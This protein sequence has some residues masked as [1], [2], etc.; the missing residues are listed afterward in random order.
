MVSKR[1]LRLCSLIFVSLLAATGI[2][3]CRGQSEADKKGVL[4]GHVS[5]VLMG[6][7]TPDGERAVTFSTDETARLWDLKSGNEIRQYTGH[8]GPLYCG[9]LSGDGRTLV[10]GAQDNTLRLWDVPQLRPVMFLAGHEGKVG[11][12]AVSPDGRMIVSGAADKAVRLWDIGNVAD[13]IAAKK[14][15]LEA[16]KEYSLRNGHGSQV[17]TA[18]WRNDSANF[19]TA[20]ADGRIFVWSPYLDAPQ[21]EIGLHPGGVT[22]LAFPNNNQQLISTGADGVIRFWQLPIP[23]T[24]SFEGNTAA[25]SAIAMVTNQAAGVVGAADGTLRLFDFNTGTVTRELPKSDKPVT[26]ADVQPNN[27]LIA[28]ADDTGRVRLLNF[29]DGADRGSILG[30]DGAVNR[31]L[32]HPDNT[33]LATAG[34][35]GTV[36]LWTIP[37]TPVPT[38]GHSQPL[39]A[40]AAANNGQWF[41]TGAD[42]KT[43]RVWAA[44]GQAQRQLGNHLQPVTVVAVRGDDAQIASG[45]EEGKI[46]LWNAG[47]GAAEGSLSA[48]TGPVRATAFEASNQSLLTGGDDGL[49]KR[50]QLPLVEPRLSNGHSQP[51]QAVAVAPDGS[52]MVTGSPDATVRVWNLS[53]GQQVRTLDGQTGPVH[54][55]AISPNGQQ[56]AAVGEAGQILVWKLADGALE[57]KRHGLAGALHDVAF[58]PDGNGLVTVDADQA[59]RLWHL[60]EAAKEIANDGAPYQVAAVSVD[61]KLY[62]VAGQSGGKHAV[63]VRER[64]SGKVVATLTGH[65]AAVTALAFDKS[66]NRLITGSADKT[67]RVWKLDGGL[68]ELF[69]HEG[70]PGTVLAVALSDDA[71]T[72]FSSGSENVVRQWNVADGSEIRSIAGHSAA[73]RGLAVRGDT[74]FSAADDGTV[75][76]WNVQNGAAIRTLN[77]G[78][79]LRCLSVTADGT[80]VVSGGTD[81]TAKLWN[82]ADGALISTFAGA[83]AEITAAVFSHD[84]S[85]VAVA[86]TDG[87]RVWQSDGRSVEHI[88]APAAALQGVVWS[89]D[90][91]SLLVCRT[92]GKV[93]QHGLSV[94]Q[95]VPLPDAGTTCVAVAPDGK[96]LFA[97][98]TGKVVRV[99]SLAEGRVANVASTKSFTGPADVVTDITVSGDGKLLAASSADKSAYVWDL[100]GTNPAAMQKFDHATAVRG[101]SLT[102]DGNRLAAAGDD[103][104]TVLWDLKTRQSAERIPGPAQAIRAVAVTGD[105]KLVVTA[106]QDNSV[107]TLTPAVTML[108]TASEAGPAPEAVTHLVPLPGDAGF[109]ALNKS[110]KGVLRWNPDGTQ[111]PSL[112]PPE[113][114]LNSLR[115]SADGLR[116]LATSATGQG[117]AWSVADGKLQT[118]LKFGGKISDAA[119]HRDGAEVAV[120]DGQSRVRVFSLEPFRLLEEIATPAAV[121]NVEWTGADGRQLATIGPQNSGSVATRSLQRLWDGLTGGAAT[122][123]FPTNGAQVFAAGKDGTIHQWRTA[124]GVLER[125]LKGHTMAVTDLTVTPNGQQLL[126][127]GKDKTLRQWNLADGSAMQSIAHAGVVVGVSVRSDSQ[128]AAT[129]SEDGQVR[130]WD[131]PSGVLLQTFASHSKEGSAVRWLPDGVTLVSGAVDKTLAGVKTSIIRAIPAHEKP[132]ADLA[133]YAGGAQVVTCSPDAQVVL[134]DLNGGQQVRKF[135]GLAAEPRCVAA[136]LDNQRIAA[137]TADGKLLVWN[138]GN[139]QLLQTIEVGQAVTALAYSADN[140]KLAVLDE[141]NMLRIYGPPV[142]PQQA[143]GGI[144]LFLHQEISSPQPLTRIAFSPDNRSVW[145]AQGDGAVSEWAY[146]SPGQIRQF[147]HGGS[148]YGVALSRD[149]KTV[150][151]CSADQTVRVWDAV[152]GQQRFQLNGHVGAVH[153]V[154]LSPDESLIV[155]SGADKTVRL[156]DLTG[157]RQL[158]QLATLD[159][160]MYSVAV[161]PDGKLV[162]AAG[163]DHKVHVYEL[164]TGAERLT[165]EGHTDYIH[166]V[167][168]NPQGTR[169]LSYGNA[170]QLRIWNAAD[171]KLLFEH[172]VGKI[173]NFADYAADGKRALLSNGDATAQIFEIPESAR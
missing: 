154:A 166:C 5:P 12:V 151:S 153:A 36:R 155:S 32:F 11:G 115:A 46:W 71:V 118:T 141:K 69:K 47:N 138:A 68:A 152:T 172:R 136:R 127:T 84:S 107:R 34:A 124:D 35:D 108:L 90:A 91:D 117:Y 24:R 14:P 54:S 6:V 72:A 160:T 167:T 31:V 97:S 65:E 132:I 162:A 22:G 142:P 95:V 2:Q 119:F 110:G 78:G 26:S 67:V 106:G 80:K 38:N 64:D 140:Q 20:D 45:D 173:G 8:T 104:S 10:T 83:T 21:G 55:V 94:G 86:A 61:G 53:N 98:G 70:Y 131:L 59:L 114:D 101:V 85:R 51:V 56:A 143:Q 37:T 27:A 147:N 42:D 4:R 62:A 129:I 139:A 125:E 148:V 28:V 43:V 159:E 81:K 3:L 164:L 161:H 77:H 89:K 63:I 123:A 96:S 16:G 130:V 116:L 73:I 105:G 18:A 9:A 149:G 41:V 150:V 146:A 144:E 58:L 7:F 126:S 103:G 137:G 50:W 75:R 1:W 92:D 121:H 33:R 156:W 165:L 13:A 60:P 49:I 111:L 109:A 145:A 19:A 29:G 87:I 99:W 57:H 135:E 134:T 122:L 93:E 112:P 169:L 74:L 102:A 23:A 168:F 88:P 44:N 100:G 79:N 171:E 39:R 48:H 157:G 76:S 158:K 163:A 40:I 15:M 113:A 30:H 52:V 66:G 17:T 170:G 25:V 133:M 82:A 120:A 128:R